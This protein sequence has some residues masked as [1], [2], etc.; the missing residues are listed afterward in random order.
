MD[1][2]LDK[3]AY[4]DRAFPIGE[5]QPF[6]NLTLSLTNLSSSTL[7]PSIKCWRLERDAYQSAVLAEMGA[8]VSPLRGKRTL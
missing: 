2:A 3:I 5:G 8:Q 4:E 6:H 7:S 1:S